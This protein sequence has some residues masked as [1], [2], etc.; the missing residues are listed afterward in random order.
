MIEID[1]NLISV[2]VVR[3]GKCQKSFYCFCALGAFGDIFG[4]C[5]DEVKQ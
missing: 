5:A 1:K 3:L 4:V 2:G